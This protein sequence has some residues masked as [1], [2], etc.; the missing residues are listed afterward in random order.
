[1]VPPTNAD[2]TDADL[3]EL[4]LQTL[5]GARD[6]ELVP[7]PS[8]PA[9]P[10]PLVAVASSDTEIRVGYGVRVP[11]AIRVKVD[12]VVAAMHPSARPGWEPEATAE[13]E[14]LVKTVL[15][16]GDSWAGPSFV[17][18]GP[19]QGP[20]QRPGARTVTSS[21]TDPAR[22]AG[23]MP[24]DD[25]LALTAPWAAV[26]GGGSGDEVAAVCE[27]ARATPHAVEAGVWT[28]EAHRRKGHATAATTAW[29]ALVA[30]RTAFYSTTWDNLASQGVARAAGLRAIGQI[31]RVLPAERFS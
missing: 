26:L 13:I 20:A 30:D 1:M 11:H 25:R 18:D 15:A 23:R 6:G 22:L 7:A 14:R 10:A 29:A 28:Y 17:V 2:P 3:L 8:A 27:T 5:W 16:T 21:D 31:W 4:E 9:W 19:P 24:D 12:A